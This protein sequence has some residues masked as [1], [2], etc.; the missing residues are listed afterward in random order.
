[1]STVIND[2]SV[3]TNPARFAD[4]ANWP[5]VVAS[6]RRTDPVFR[7]DVDGFPK[8]WALTKHAGV[9]E[10]EKRHDIFKNTMRV[11]VLSLKAEAMADQPGGAVE[12]LVH[13]DDPKHRKFRGLTAGWFKPSVLRANMAEKVD[14][15]CD[16]FIRRMPDRRARAASEHPTPLPVVLGHEGAGVV[17][18]VGSSV[19]SVAPAITWY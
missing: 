2:G 19:T 12:T 8:Y 4:D 14:T 11:E 10:I 16:E 15:L 5:E 1:L 7:V 13:M 9:S 6:I 3:F 18:R 17:E